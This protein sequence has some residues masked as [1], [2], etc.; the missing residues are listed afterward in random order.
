MLLLLLLVV[1][2]VIVVVLVEVLVFILLF[3]S[4]LSVVLIGPP[5]LHERGL[6]ARDAYYI[7]IG[8][9]TYDSLV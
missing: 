1:V 7:N 3:I 9:I 8:V 5:A 2:V 4:L 6:G